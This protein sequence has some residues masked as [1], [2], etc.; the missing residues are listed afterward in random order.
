MKQE[1][2]KKKKEQQDKP[3]LE[4]NSVYP[5]IPGVYFVVSEG[6]KTLDKSK[7]S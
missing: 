4:D 1:Q 5:D 7:H 6:P 3:T 2:D